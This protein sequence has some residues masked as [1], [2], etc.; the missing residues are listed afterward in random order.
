MI[1]IETQLAERLITEGKVKEELN[2]ENVS[3]L[4]VYAGKTLHSVTKRLNK[5]AWVLECTCTNG[6]FHKNKST[7]CVG[8][9]AY[10][11]YYSN[12]LRIRKEIQKIKEEWALEEDLGIFSKK[13]KC[14]LSRFISN[15]E[16]LEDIMKWRKR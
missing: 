12:Y 3:V 14:L 6:T 1:N 9:Q 11:L 13:E 5:G 4:N 8:K 10:V 7:I 2:T 15:I 16:G